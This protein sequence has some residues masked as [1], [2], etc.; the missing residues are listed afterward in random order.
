M[1]I[2]RT[3]FDHVFVL[4]PRARIDNRGFMNIIYGKDYD[5]LGLD[6]Q[7][8]ETRIYSMPR[9]GTFFG[10][11]Y[12][13]E[14]DPLSKLVT[15]VNGCGMDYV[16]DLRKDSPTYLKWEAVKLSADIPLLVYIPAG[17]GHA[18]I[19][20]AD[21]TIQLFSVDRDGENSYSKSINYRD[22]R[23]ALKLEI[24]VVEIAEYDKNAPFID[25]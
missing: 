12:R 14:S 20:L 10:I 17:F 21:N 8:K 7:I 25:D 13:D 3:I 6:F 22:E 16:I 23:I 2:V 18:F 11:H 4:K 24:P 5:K 15:V 1:E 19:S 9:K